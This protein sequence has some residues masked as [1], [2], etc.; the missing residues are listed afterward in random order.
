MVMLFPVIVWTDSWHSAQHV[1][2]QGLYDCKVSLPHIWTHFQRPS[3]VK[4][5]TG[6]ILNFLTEP[7]TSFI[8]TLE[9]LNMTPTHLRNQ[10]E[11]TMDLGVITD[12][13]CFL[14]S[15]TRQINTK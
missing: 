7:A 12:K 1:S 2:V 10:N 5:T 14:P 13:N 3:G 15:I 6:I 11:G 9:A 4:T 8:Y